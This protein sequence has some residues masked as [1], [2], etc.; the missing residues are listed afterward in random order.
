LRYFSAIVL[1]DI[2]FQRLK[3]R[4]CIIVSFAVVKRW[5][6]KPFQGEK[7]LY[8]LIYNKNLFFTK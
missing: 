1:A 2:I 4:I 7:F 3:E 6:S 5:F 8:K